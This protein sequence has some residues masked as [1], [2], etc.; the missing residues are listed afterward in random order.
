MALFK[1]LNGKG[2]YHDDNARETVVEYILN[3][4]KARHGYIGGGY[5]NM[6]NVESI[7]GSMN[8]VAQEFGKVN[9]VQLRHFVISFLP[10]ETRDPY[11]VYQIGGQI[12]M[13]ICLEYQTVFAVHEDTDNLHIHLMLNSISHQDGH[14]YA[15]TR[16]DYYTLVNCIGKV[17]R[18]HGIRKLIPVSYSSGQDIQE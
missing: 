2:R 13:A 18:Q 1:F 17:L 10:Q 15:G 7:V 8:K 4:Y 9:G 5:V 3:P 6:E 12:T 14:R 16:K 11:M